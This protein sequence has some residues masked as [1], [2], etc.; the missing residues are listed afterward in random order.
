MIPIN[1]AIDILQTYDL[2]KPIC[3]DLETISFD[4]KRAG[5]NPYRGDRIAVY[6]VAQN[7]KEPL[8]ACV[9]HRRAPS[10]QFRMYDLTDMTELMKEFCK[11]IKIYTNQNMKFDLRFMACEGVT[12][13][14]STEFRDPMV[15]ARLFRNDLMSYS[16]DNLAKMYLDPELRKKTVIIK[17]YLDMFKSKD[18]AVTPVDKFLE[19]AI[20]DCWPTLAL[21]DFF[22][23]N[24]HKESVDLMKTEFAITRLFFGSEHHGIHLDTQFLM[25]KRLVGLRNIIDLT[26]KVTAHAS[27][28]MPRVIDK[29][30]NEKL[31]EFNA[32]SP[33]QK[34]V[35]FDKLGVKPIKY[36]VDDQ[37]KKT[38]RPSWDADVLGQI[39]PLSVEDREV[40][41]EAFDMAQMLLEL[42]DLTKQD[43]TYLAGWLERHTK[44]V[45]H[46]DLKQTGTTT[47]RVSSGDPNTQNNPKWMM[48][49]FIIPEGKVGIQWDLSQIEYRLFAHYSGDA[50][51]IKK[52][53]DN[54]NI[55]F[56]QI[57]ADA[58][59]IPRDS[60]KPI[61]FGI[62]Y[63]MGKEKLIIAI[64]LAILKYDSQSFRDN[65][66][67]YAKD[68][69]PPYPATIESKVVREIATS[70]LNDYHVKNPGVKYLNK[71]IKD[72]LYQRGYIKSYYGMRYYM[73]PDLA[74]VATNRLLQ[75]SAAHYFKS[76]LVEIHRECPE[77]QLINNIHDA[78]YS[79][80]DV[81]YAQKF[82]DVS[83]R[84]IERPLFR[85][86]IRMDGEV[87]IDNWH[88]KRKIKNHCVMSNLQYLMEG[89]KDKNH[90][91]VPF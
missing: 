36:T 55:D 28:R 4:D 85:V 86:P 17:T 75:G 72:L 65:L 62:M 21:H 63:G 53:N 52:Y 73:T 30:G 11:K 8:G 50:E 19:Y 56:H 10:E 31:Y 37:G 14:A 67:K 77:A 76:C 5:D 26:Q 39:T 7:G 41:Q 66:Q 88:N 69:I 29:K 20:G 27:R 83:R 51:L 90:V 45:I 40:G 9:R 48:E 82:Y 12:F 79:I 89:V 24:M 23:L 34:A 59:G 38:D 22:M 16:L 47:G 49:A 60:V 61:N 87:A 54:P 43:G 2:E 91:I 81:E 3:I 13:D 1:T 15:M 42:A 32:N 33:Q 6:A 64:L 58:L 80:M 25:R 46:P 74:Y 78:D 84:V 18:Y 71:T 68:D 70:V 35:Y 57:I 44:G